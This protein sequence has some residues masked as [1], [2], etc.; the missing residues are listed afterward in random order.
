M[1]EKL[2]AEELEYIQKAKYI[3]DSIEVSSLALYQMMKDEK[4][5][6]DIIK[7]LNKIVNYESMKKEFMESVLAVKE[8]VRNLESSIE[9]TDS[10]MDR[11]FDTDENELKNRYE[12]KMSCLNMEEES[13]TNLNNDISSQQCEIS[14]L[15]TE[16]TDDISLLNNVKFQESTVMEE[17]ILSRENYESNVKLA[18][19]ENVLLLRQHESSQNLLN[20]KN[21]LKRSLLLS[22]S[23]I[24]DQ[25][26]DKSKQLEDLVNDTALQEANVLLSSN[27]EERSNKRLLITSKLMQNE[28]TIKA[29]DK[30][31]SDTKSVLCHEKYKL[32]S[33][34]K[35][36][37]EIKTSV[38]SVNQEIFS[39]SKDMEELRENLITL[40]NK[41]SKLINITH[42]A[43]CSIF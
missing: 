31:L 9:E 39:Q 4:L 16:I 42:I 41:V 2:A 5:D 32:Q 18:N 27:I 20:D 19:D 23:T 14:K 30:L 1:K 15:Q 26:Q 29:S 25:I 28:E 22:Q 12:S 8:T 33:F 6:S 24:N 3:G 43:I 17:I 36:L 38:D 13:I 35:R 21:G 7:L 11:L 10:T 37:D 40:Q 34:Q